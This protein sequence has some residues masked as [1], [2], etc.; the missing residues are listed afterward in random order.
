[1]M[2]QEAFTDF[3]PISLVVL[4][5]T[6]FC[7]INCNYCYVPGRTQRIRMSDEVFIGIARNILGSKFTSD[8]IN[9]CWHSGEPL[10]LPITY[11]EKAFRIL[12]ENA[13]ARLQIRHEF[14]T[15]ATL[16][17]SDWISFLSAHSAKVSI[18]L[19]GPE[20]LHDAARVSR[21]GQGTHKA[22]IRGLRL[23]VESGIKPHVICVLTAASLRQPK[24]IFKFFEDH[25]VESILF[26]VEETIGEHLSKYSDDGAAFRE[27]LLIY[28]KQTTIF[29]SA[30][31]IQN[32]DSV[33]SRLFSRFPKPLFE[34]LYRPFGHISVGVSGDY[35]T[36][37]PELG[38]DSDAKNFILGN[39][40]RNP[41]GAESVATKIEK[42]NEEIQ[43]GIEICRTNCGYFSLC[44]GGSPGH[45]YSEGRKLAIGKTAF[46]QNNIIAV[47]DALSERAVN[48]M[49]M[50]WTPE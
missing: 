39:V 7:N 8:I 17:N 16:I 50:H 47:A 25:G 1:M 33:A 38:L 42:L 34:T 41:L 15:N 44:G 31:R 37:S 23:L 12:S 32:I 4:Q 36:Y 22:S 14:Q 2:A 21:S 49:P 46:C 24:E 18:S 43:K 40:L 20:E 6:S 9:L 13:P 19:D 5:P 35:W 48:Q 30:Q 10:T 45:K 27:F 26:N 28:L 3:L 11:Y 29:R